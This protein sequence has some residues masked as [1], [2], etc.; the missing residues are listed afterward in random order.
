MRFHFS[1]EDIFIC[2][3]YRGGR[4]VAKIVPSRSQAHSNTHMKPFREQVE[5][6]YELAQVC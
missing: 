5:I 3:Y 2:T 1:I 6:G 4:K